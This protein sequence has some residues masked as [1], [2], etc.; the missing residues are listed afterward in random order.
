MWS[1]SAYIPLPAPSPTLFE[2]SSRLSKNFSRSK[3]SSHLSP[4]PLSGVL[5]L[6]W[7]QRKELTRWECALTF[8]T[9][10]SMLGK[11]N[12]NVLPWYRLLLILPQI[13][14]RCLQS[15]MP[16]K[17]TISAPLMKK[18]S[19]LPHSLHPLVDSS[20]CKPR[21]ASHP[22]LRSTTGGWMRPVLACLG[23]NID[24]FVDDVI[25][26][27]SD[28]TKHAAH[29]RQFLKRC[30]EHNMITLNQNK[31]EYAQSQVTFARFQL[32]R[33]I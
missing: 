11:R 6:W 33:R 8:H 4:N 14:Q 28:E 21:M 15:S 24:A 19:S 31:W 30:A 13:M 3:T 12:T 7:L 10:I 25:I 29:V 18:A 27:D 17:D 2:A 23:I 5:P 9:W 26:C 22:F 32:P 1:S 16:S 20:I